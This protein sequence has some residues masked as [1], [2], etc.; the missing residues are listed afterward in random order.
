MAIDRPF[1]ISSLGRQRATTTMMTTVT[2]S[3]N[4]RSMCYKISRARARDRREV[5][6]IAR[7]ASDGDSPSTR[8]AE[9][10]DSLRRTTCTRIRATSRTTPEAR[11]T[12]NHA[13]S[14]NAFAVAWGAVENARANARDQGARARSAFAS[15]DFASAAFGSALCCGMFVWR[16]QSVTH[17]MAIAFVSTI[18]A[19]VVETC[20]RDGEREMW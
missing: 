17:A 9:E 15:Y 16:G 5:N 7:F 6:V 8:I 4:G 12:K 13:K 19:V 18:V 20:A 3:T 14:I 10:D 11:A 1:A 2:S